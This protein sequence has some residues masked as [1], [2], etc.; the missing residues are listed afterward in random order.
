MGAMCRKQTKGVVVEL[1]V[2]NIVFAGTPE[3]IE[4]I[5]RRLRLKWTPF[6][7]G[8]YHEG[9]ADGGVSSVSPEPKH[10]WEISPGMSGPRVGDPWLDGP[11]R[12]SN[13]KPVPLGVTRNVEAAPA[14]ERGAEP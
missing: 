6:G 9:A 7:D 2:D 12:L 3:E 14:A 4:E 8:K 11:G 13:P 5:V 1:K 10:G